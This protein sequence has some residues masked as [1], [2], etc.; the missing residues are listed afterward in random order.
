MVLKRFFKRNIVF[1]TNMVFTCTENMK[2]TRYDDRVCLHLHQL[3]EKCPSD[4]SKLWLYCESRQTPG[5]H[6][7]IMDVLDLGLEDLQFLVARVSENTDGVELKN[8]SWFDRV[9]NYRMSLLNC[10]TYPS[11]QILL[12]SYGVSAE[13]SHVR[14]EFLAET[15][16]E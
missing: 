10:H 4:L 15:R 3:S 1:V 9:G 14:I 5:A 7:T 6:M 12:G 8:I 2:D 16:T 13:K 11:I